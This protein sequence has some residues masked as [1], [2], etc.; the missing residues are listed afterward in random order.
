MPFQQR[1]DEKEG[2]SDEKVLQLGNMGN[3]ESDL[4]E[5]CARTFRFES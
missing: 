1:E 3:M 5:E 4:P 2:I